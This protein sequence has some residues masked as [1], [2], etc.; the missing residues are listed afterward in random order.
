MGVL[1]YFALT[2]T[3]SLIPLDI[4]EATYLSPPPTSIL[5]TTDLIAQRAIELQK[6]RED[7]VRVTKR[8]YEARNRAAQT[9]ERNHKATIWDFNFKRGALVLVRN[10]AIEKSLNRKMRTRYLGPLIVIARNRGRAYM[11]SELDGAVL[12]RPVAA[13]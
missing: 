12:N 9:F 2:D 7:L 5:S 8:V 6:C 4:I 13:F 1:P 10:M 11:F 3:H